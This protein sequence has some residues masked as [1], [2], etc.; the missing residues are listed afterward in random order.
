MMLKG[1]FSHGLNG[2]SVEKPSNVLHVDPDDLVGHCGDFCSPNTVL[3]DS[4]DTHQSVKEPNAARSA[5]PDLV[6]SLPHIYRD[7][8][9]TNTAMMMCTMGRIS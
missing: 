8:A 7:P 1:W 6:A 2:L 4:V 3:C 9:M 5:Q